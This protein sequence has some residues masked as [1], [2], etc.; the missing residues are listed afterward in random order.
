MGHCDCHTNWDC[1]RRG[2]AWKRIV[3]TQE[4]GP[5]W[6]DRLE[7]LTLALF[8]LTQRAECPGWVNGAGRELLRDFGATVT[9][10]G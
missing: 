9:K 5:G 4:G 7:A 8:D 2:P 1:G 3:N 6:L 10:G